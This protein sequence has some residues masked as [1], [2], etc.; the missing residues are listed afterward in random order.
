MIL[1]ISLLIGSCTNK[2]KTDYSITDSKK[3]TQ[4]KVNYKNGIKTLINNFIR[5]KCMND[6]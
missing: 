5:K 4:I 3:R 6:H 2:E 1:F